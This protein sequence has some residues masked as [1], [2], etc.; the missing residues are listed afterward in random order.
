MAVFYII[1]TEAEKFGTVNSQEII[2]EVKYQFDFEADKQLKLIAMMT[3]NAA[4][5]LRSYKNAHNDSSMP[6]EHAQL[7]ED[8][9]STFENYVCKSAY[10]QYNEELQVVPYSLKTW[11][12]LDSNFDAKCIF[13]GYTTGK[14][15]MT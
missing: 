8:Q 13:H 1:V 10:F 9:K 3:A 4:A 7:T 5:A 11:Y 14:G 2:T 15:N 12:K 6:D